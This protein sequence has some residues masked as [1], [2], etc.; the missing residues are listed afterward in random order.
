M[1][2]KK[3]GETKVISDIILN[4]VYEFSLFESRQSIIGSYATW[5]AFFCKQMLNESL[6]DA[7]RQNLSLPLDEIAFL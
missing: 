2:F 6:L 7:E 5:G 3:V 4:A 1:L